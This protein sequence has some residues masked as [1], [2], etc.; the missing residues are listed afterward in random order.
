MTE[1]VQFAL[2][3]L[4]AGGA[5]AIAG[6]GMTQIYRGSGV[7]NLAHGAMALVAAVVF[8]WADQR[9]HLPLLVAGLV[10]VGAGALLGALVEVLVMRPLRDAAPLVRIIATLGVMAVLQQ[11]VPLLFGTDFQSQPVESFYPSGS[12]RLGDSV[13]ITFDRLILVGITLALALILRLS[14]TSTKFGLETIAG[15]ENALVASTLGVNTKRVGLLNW[16]IGSAAA[17]LAGVL[18]VP[19]L[20]SLIPNPLILLVIPALAAAMI[21]R[22]TSYGLTVVGGLLIGIGQ[23]LLVRYQ[24]A[25]FGD[26]LGAG[27][28]DALPFLV[29]I[30]ILVVGGAK[31]PKRSEV[32]ARLPRV[33]RTTVSPFV[34]IGVSLVAAA[35]MLICS[36]RLAGQFVAMSGYA[37]V[38][39]SLVVITGLA[40]QT[41]LAQFSIAAVAA[42]ASAAVSHT[43][44]WPFP[45]VMVVGIAAGTAAGLAFALPA[46]RTR[47]PTL[48]IATLGVGV[49][50]Q[51][52]VYKNGNLTL[53]D[54]YGGT[55]VEAPSLLG[56]DLSTAE[57]PQR[58]AALVVLALGLAAVGVS[59]L[60]SSATGRRLLAVRSSERAAAAAGIR[61]TGAKTAAFVIA[62]A[63]ASLGGVLLAFQHQTVLYD[64]YDV[65]ASLN[66]VIF[67]LIGGVGYVLG[68]IFGAVISPS[69]IF[70][71]IFHGHESVQ[72]WLLAIGGFG[73]ILCLIFY[74]HGQTEP[75]GALW[76]KIWRRRKAPSIRVA[77]P[78]PV[79]P[80]TELQ[81]R[82][83]SVGY[84]TVTAV[85]ALDLSIKP[86]HIVGL[87][88]PNGAGKTTAIDAI[89]GFVRIRSGSI[90]LGDRDMVSYGAHKRAASGVGRTFQMV[91]LF[92]DLTVAENLAVSVERVRW[93]H[94]VTDLVRRRVVSLPASV[95]EQA[96]LLGLND[97]SLSPQELSQGQRRILGVLR[98]IASGP[99]V[100]LLDEPAAG[101]NR[102]ETEHLSL[103]L[104][105]LADDLGIGMLLVEHDL[106]MVSAICDHVVAIDFGKTIFDGSVEQAVDDAAIR[107]AYLGDAGP[108]TGTVYA[109]QKG[110]S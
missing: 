57:H 56:I 87:I 109:D 90:S 51:N 108:A 40:G 9:W 78:L 54:V 71:Y 13:G 58:Y 77:Q 2:L 70:T 103:V 65:I 22:F 99:C 6:I 82:G 44:A 75:F 59:N 89:S 20:G 106:S 14:M 95:L 105:Q 73:L 64:G 69:G 67:T 104:R 47:G 55:P 11:A 31:F 7:L 18:L 60:R 29:V 28:P 45:V 42:L 15:A 79:R 91:E 96:A 98:A 53:A 5:Y 3:G 101:L 1:F 72:R 93:W 84:G 66:L 97:L 39:L 94:W 38:G 23:S 92:D 102:A 52:V 34:G 19:I 10:A 63:I 80:P 25:I 50:L 8:V 68:P 46:F 30:V 17:G 100:L 62:A 33:G 85:D 37:I 26:K 21:G 32:A 24:V 107:A 88:G 86:G 76:R 27:W 61:L 48:A 4:G 16:G 41:A 81:V 49:A 43:Y 110:E 83:L 12:V 74:P 36:D 35:L